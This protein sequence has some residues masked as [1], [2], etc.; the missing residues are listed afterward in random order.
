MWNFSWVSVGYNHDAENPLKNRRSEIA[1]V[2]LDVALT[3]LRFY[4]KSER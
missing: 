3:D 1:D 4:A 2:N